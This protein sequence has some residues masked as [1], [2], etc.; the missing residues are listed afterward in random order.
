MSE[1]PER[2]FGICVPMREEPDVAV[3]R[4]RV[5]EVALEA[6]LDESATEALATATSE[7]ARNVVVHASGGEILLGVVNERHRRGVVVIARDGGPGIADPE[8]AMLDG[9]ST[10]QTLGIGLSGARRLVD[11][12]ELATKV[13]AG[14]TVTMKK[15]TS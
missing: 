4:Q 12:F 8:R 2:L 15:W 3:A 13:G 6:G 1:V 7:I 5:R 11:E 14:T 10:T 9:Y